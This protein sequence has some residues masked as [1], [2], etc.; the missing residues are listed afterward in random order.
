MRKIGENETTN[1]RRPF[2]DQPVRT[3]YA[4]LAASDLS[5]SRP[6]HRLHVPENALGTRGGM[7]E[8]GG[9]V[10]GGNQQ[11]HLPQRGNDRVDLLQLVQTIAIILDHLLQAAHLSLDAAQ[12]QE[13]RVTLGRSSAQ[14]HTAVQKIVFH[15][16]STLPRGMARRL[17][18][19]PTCASRTGRGAS[20]MFYHDKRLQYPVKVTTPDP[21]FARMLQQAIG[22]V[23]G[24]IRVRMQYL[25]QS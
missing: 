22:G 25:F 3:H 1:D 21:I 17:W 6:Q 5:Q 16:L 23:E 20:P 7:D 4:T 18:T 14:Q 11:S 8:A 15:A 24:E 10:L 9:E 12:P 13:H 19:F 2:D